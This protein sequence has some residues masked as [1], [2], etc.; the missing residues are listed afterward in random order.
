M[1][2]LL[3]IIEVP[4]Q[5]ELANWQQERKRVAKICYPDRPETRNSAYSD[6]ADACKLL[7][8]ACKSTG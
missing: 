6:F 7:A 2:Q 4:P 8:D 3:F 1:L 5:R